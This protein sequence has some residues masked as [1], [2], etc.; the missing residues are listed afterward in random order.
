MIG[1]SLLFY[2]GLKGKLTVPGE[3]TGAAAFERALLLVMLQQLR[4]SPLRLLHVDENSGETA[5][6]AVPVVRGRRA[7]GLG[8]A[9]QTQDG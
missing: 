3:A 4:S 9:Q 6:P 2:S 5:N 7:P 8:A 1:F